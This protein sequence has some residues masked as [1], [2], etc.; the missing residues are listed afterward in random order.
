M[1]A[2]TLLPSMERAESRE[3]TRMNRGVKACARGTIR[4]WTDIEVAKRFLVGRGP[5]LL[6]I[7]HKPV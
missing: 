2:V 3:E 6:R 4:S 7:S 1:C 5:C